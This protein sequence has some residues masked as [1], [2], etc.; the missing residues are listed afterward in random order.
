MITDHTNVLEVPSEEKIN[1]ILTRYK[2]FNK[3]GGSYVWKRLGRPLDM[4]KTLAENGIEDED[5][6]FE[7]LGIEAS[8][9]YIPTI[10]LFFSDDLTFA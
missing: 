7:K 10:H 9:W 6:E 2:N 4:E 5:P 3:H 1:E 8:Q